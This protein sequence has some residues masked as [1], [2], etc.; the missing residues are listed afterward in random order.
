MDYYL[1][2]GHFYWTMTPD[3]L[4]G[5]NAIVDCVNDDGNLLS[6]R[7]LDTNGS[8]RPVVS[9]RSDAISGGRGTMTDPFV[10]G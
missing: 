1:Y 6:N 7:V 5:G 10:V 2:T 4:A 3:L 9:L 8:A